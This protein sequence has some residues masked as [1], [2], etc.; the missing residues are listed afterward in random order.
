V[1]H[2]RLAF[3]Q[4]NALT[5]CLFL[6][7]HLKP[8]IMIKTN[9][10]KWIADFFVAAL[11]IPLAGSIFSGL[12]TLN[13]QAVYVGAKGGWS[14][15]N[16]SGGNNEISKGWKSRSAFNFGVLVSDEL[17]KKFTLQLEVNYASQGA[18]KNGIQPLSDGAIPGL[19]TGMTFYSD[20]KS[21]AILNYVEVPVLAKFVVFQTRSQRFYIDAGPYAG[22]LLNARNK[23]SGTSSIFTD[24]SG[25]LLMIPNPQNP[26]QYIPLLAQ[27]FDANTNITSDIKKFNFGINGGVGIGQ[28]LGSGNLFL[29]IKGYYGFLNIQKNPVNGKNNSG[30]LVVSVGYAVKID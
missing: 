15:P 12:N 17:T 22:Y 25:T 9:V 14:L 18:R 6:V 21:Q 28:N 2:L 19:P 11:I 10:P 16:L 13:A 24:K 20:F 3:D 29:D 4:Q 30:A 26:D 1:I 7:I 27:S 8:L 5:N 23:T